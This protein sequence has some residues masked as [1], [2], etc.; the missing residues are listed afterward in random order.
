MTVVFAIVLVVHGLIHLLGF[1]KA[2]RLADLPQ[3]T[4]PIS[5]LVGVLWLSAAMLFLGAAGSLFLWPRWW[6]AIGA[7]AVV[8]SMVAIVPSW[9]DAKFGALA[10]V[11]ALVGVIFGFLAHG[12]TSLRAAY[13]RDADCALAIASTWFTSRAAPGT[14]RG[15][16]PDS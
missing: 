2:F 5:P 4:Q 15:S 3:L 13:E 6:W 9:T 14:P 7:G 8:V 12:P 16:P 10:N 11:V 1:A